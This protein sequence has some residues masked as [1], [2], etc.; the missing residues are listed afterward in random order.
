MKYIKTADIREFITRLANR[1]FKRVRVRAIIKLI[2]M[3]NGM[4]MTRAIETL[5]SGGLR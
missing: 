5:G 2:A 3:T 4:R 1:L